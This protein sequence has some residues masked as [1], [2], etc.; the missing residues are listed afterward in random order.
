MILADKIIRLRKRFGM[1]QEELAERMSVSRQAVSKWESGGAIPDLDKIL[2]LGELFGVTTDYLL[3]DEIE[4][5]EFTEGED[6]PS[7][8]RVSLDKANA[9]LEERR[10]ASWKIALATFLCIISPI[11]LII[12]GAAS[13]LES[14]NVSEKTVGIIGLS[15]LFLFVLCAVPIFIYC[16]FKNERFAYLDKISTF[17]LE[18][19]VRGIVTERKNRFRDTYVRHNIIA[20]CMCIFSP[21]PLI[22]SGFAD[23]GFLSAVMLGVTMLI[24]GAGVF[25]FILFGVRNGSMQRLLEEGEFSKDEKQKSGVREAVVFAYWGILTAGYLAWSFLSGDWHLTWLVFAVGGVLFPIVMHACS[26]ILDKRSKND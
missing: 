5:E 25:I 1:S 21:V 9:Y 20:A 17:E 4:G 14:F 7:V 26:L 19:G 16:G 12:L 23:N 24:A 3:K 13:E 10:R 15:A 2:K 22:L 18:Y 6:T 11:P 8:K